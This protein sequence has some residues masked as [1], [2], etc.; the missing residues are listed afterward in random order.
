MWTHEHTGETDA[1]PEAVWKV[2]ADLDDW[3]SW[4]TSMEWVRLRGAFAPGGEVVMKP[5]GQDPITSVIAEVTENRVYADETEF[6]GLTLRFSHT[7]RP[8][9]DG[10]TKVIH[11]L[12]I[13][14]PGEIAAS[15]GPAITEDFPEAM[16]ALLARAAA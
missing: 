12:E 14:G 2:L 13:T 7:L 6:E 11:R 3:A 16:A 8:R 1:A 10:G 9:E 5:K 15:V 4:D